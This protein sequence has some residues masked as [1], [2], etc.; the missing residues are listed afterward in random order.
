MLNWIVINRTVG[1]FNYVS[2]KSVYKLYIL[3]MGIKSPAMVDMQ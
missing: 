1:S 3:G 2:T